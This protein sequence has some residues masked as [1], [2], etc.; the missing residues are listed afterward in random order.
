MSTA[1]TTKSSNFLPHIEGLRGLAILLILFFHISPEICPNGFLGVDVFL[2]ISGYFLFRGFMKADGN[3]WSLCGFIRKKVLRLLPPLIPL[4]IVASVAGCFLLSP[5]DL[6]TSLKTAL[7]AL[8]LSANVYLDGAS[9]GYFGTDSSFNLFLHT[10]YLGVTAQ[11]FLI[12]AVIFTLIKKCSAGI[13]WGVFGIVGLLSFGFV[14]YQA[15]GRFLHP[16]ESP[17]P[18]Y[19]LTSARL[20]EFAI[21]GFC[22]L[23]GGFSRKW[24]ADAAG[25]L[26]LLLLIVCSFF[27]NKNAQLIFIVLPAAAILVTAPGRLGSYLLNTLPL[28]RLGQYSYS[29]FLWHWPII[30]FTKYYVIEP[31]IG[32]YALLLI[33]SCA[34]GALCYRLTEKPHCGNLLLWSSWGTCLGL[35]LVLL[36]TWGFMDY[37]HSE[38][39]PLSLRPHKAYSYY[40][41]NDFP[42]SINYW[43]RGMD[44]F[45][46]PTIVKDFEFTR[47]GRGDV[48]PSFIMLGDSHAYV[49]RDGMDKIATDLGISGTY[50]PAYV[51]PFWN[52]MATAKRIQFDESAATDLIQWLG[53]HKEITH[54]VLVQLWSLRMKDCVDLP[55][56]ELHYD[57]SRVSQENAY[58]AMETALREFC[59]KL[60]EQNKEVILMEEVPF[61]DDTSFTSHSRALITGHTYPQEKQIVSLGTYTARMARLQHTFAQM[62]REG[63]CRVIHAGTCSFEN[64]VFRSYQNG[65]LLL[66]DLNHVSPEGARYVAEKTL[67]EWKQAF[68]K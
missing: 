51:T 50:L 15:L 66:R 31:G 59:T 3:T 1:N 22:L 68:G 40:S 20:Y 18:L 10:W 19:Y 27:P 34:V 55:A 58:A 30:V 26:A 38:H 43:R 67:H 8:V 44:E 42:D 29:L 62:E 49:F 46:W 4:L 37:L 24:L 6:Q 36:R 54:V 13:K 23:W 64:G 25:C 16:D 45:Y 47:M 56:L 7:S 2:L 39:I 9:S 5:S 12:F 17:M 53:K 57:G 21:G 28:R 11:A 48:A 63:L 32:T 65:A 61:I 52:R 14:C 41:Y 35:L 60:K 33:V